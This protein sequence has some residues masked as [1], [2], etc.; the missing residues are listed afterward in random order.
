MARTRML[1]NHLL[2]CDLPLIQ[3]PMAG[4]QDHR[5]AVAVAQAGGLGSIPS[6]MLTSDAL[7]LQLS[8]YRAMTDRPVNVNFFAH[9][10]PTPDEAMDKAWQ[11]ILSPYD[12]EFG[13]D[14]THLAAGASRLPFNHAMAD[15]LDA[16]KPE[17]V[18]FHFGLPS[19]DLLAR[20]KSTGAVVMSSATTIEE[21]RWLERNGA[22]IV[23]AQGLEAGGH[24]G[25]FLGDDVLDVSAQM[26][27]FALLP[28]IMRAVNVPVVAAGGIADAVGIRAVMALGAAGVQIGTSYLLCHE[29]AAST[30]HRAALSSEAATHT[31]LTNVFTGRPARGIVN[32]IMRELGAINRHAPAFPLATAAITPLRTAAEARGSNDFSPLW[33]G[34]NTSGCQ[35]IGA[36][37]LTLQLAKGFS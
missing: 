37:E 7:A 14:R 9:T 29:S 25:H 8:N 36:T 26:G 34:Q 6:A 11:T 31:R 4:S 13:V 32:R 15:V 1:L 35:A 22:D 30:I 19:P 24:R 33:A 2:S 3:A 27:T 10:S 28:H 23:I 12:H 17:V 20:V 21:A 18:S 5:L 16:F